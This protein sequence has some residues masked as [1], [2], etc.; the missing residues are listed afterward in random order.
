MPDYSWAYDPVDL[1]LYFDS[2]YNNIPSS[3]SMTWI[4][5]TGVGYFYYR[6]NTADSGYSL[7][8]NSYR[9]YVYCNRG[10]YR[11]VGYVIKGGSHLY[12]DTWVVYDNRGYRLAT[13]EGLQN[14]VIKL[15]EILTGP[16]GRNHLHE[17]ALL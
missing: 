13:V 2:D 1:N 11:I 8:P 4:S 12:G 7:P 9:V 5:P 10:S 6:S 15:N 16:D 14:G 3:D 17:D